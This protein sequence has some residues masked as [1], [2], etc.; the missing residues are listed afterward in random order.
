[1]LQSSTWSALRLVSFHGRRYTIRSLGE[2]TTSVALRQLRSVTG[3]SLGGEDAWGFIG[4]V[5]RHNVEASCGTASSPGTVAVFQLKPTSCTT[6]DSTVD[7]HLWGAG[8]L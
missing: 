6:G 8:D 1:M 4:R 7:R 2:Q 3:S 5:N